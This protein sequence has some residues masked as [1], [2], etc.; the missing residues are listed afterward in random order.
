[1]IVQPNRDSIQAA[2]NALLAGQL[3]VLPTETVYGLAADIRNETAIASIFRLKGRPNDNPLIVHLHDQSQAKFVAREL[4]DRFFQ[5]AERFW[6]GPL[7]IVLPKHRV[8]SKSITAGGETVAIR[9]PDHPV[10]LGVMSSANLMLAMPSANPFMSLSPTRADLVS[11]EIESGVW[12]ILDGGASK[13]GIEST[14]L[15]LSDQQPSILRV[16]IVS[17]QEIED[18][19]SEYIQTGG[20]STK[21]PGQYRRHYAPRTKA[22][23]VT[24]F[25]QNAHGISFSEPKTDHII[26][27]GHDPHEYAKNLYAALAELDTLGVEVIE[28]LCP[29]ETEEWAPIWDRITK[30]A[31]PL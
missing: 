5:L 4:P 20:D 22:V 26:L 15:D 1:M 24:E 30:A 11:H 3:V 10:T 12:G 13:V 23:L 29:P 21:S 6:P 19:L 25:S 7:S 2:S 28:I 27:A 16:G 8:L 9:I 18:C 31:T 14:V 17:R